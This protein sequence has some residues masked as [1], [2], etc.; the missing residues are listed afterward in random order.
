MIASLIP[1]GPGSVLPARPGDPGSARDL[2]MAGRCQDPCYPSKH[3]L[4][5]GP[6]DGCGQRPPLNRRGTPRYRDGQVAGFERVATH[7]ADGLACV[8][9]VERFQAKVGG[10]DTPAS[11]SLRVTTVY[12]EEG[13]LWRL[14]HRHADPITTPQPAESVIGG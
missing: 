10:S 13:G 7:A 11:I 2:G 4:A 6:A 8:V 12:R 1:A 14:V 9:E 3:A 5:A